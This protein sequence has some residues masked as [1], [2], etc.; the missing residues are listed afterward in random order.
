MLFYTATNT[1][2]L[3]LQAWTSRD[4]SHI[5]RKL[6]NEGGKIVSHTHRPS[7]PPRKY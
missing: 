6:A 1:T 7:L 4:G 3:P 5:S 2:V